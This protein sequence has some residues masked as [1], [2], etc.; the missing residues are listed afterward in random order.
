MRELNQR[1]RAIIRERYGG[2][3]RAA[4]KALGMD[5][6]SLQTIVDSPRREPQLST[7]AK[8]AEVFDWPFLDVIYWTMGRE[9]P[10]PAD[11]AKQLGAC[12]AAIGLAES[13]R[14]AIVELALATLA[15]ESTNTR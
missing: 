5:P 8:M 7:L 10:A 11:P 13:T 2:S 14:A 15:R 4:S 6:N 9:V 1:L 12:L 3:V